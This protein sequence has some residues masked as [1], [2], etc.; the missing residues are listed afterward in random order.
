MSN[1]PQ[2]SSIT[3]HYD[4]EYFKYQFEIGRFGG[5]ANTSKFSAYIRPDMNVLDFGC[6]CG[7]L[8]ANL[9]GKQK[10]GI[11]VNPVARAE[12]A[13]SG[14]PTVESA[15]QVPDSWADIVVSNHALEH[16]QRPLD[17]LKALVPKVALGGLVVFVV[18]CELIKNRYSNTDPNH[19]LYS[20]S[21]MSLGNLF[22]EASL[23]VIESKAYV[24]CWPPRFMSRTLRAI[25]GRLLFE[26]GCRAYGALTYLNLTPALCQA[27]VVAR[28]N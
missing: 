26:A 14:I 5:W 20:W 27:R 12:A 25:G 11:E 10:L 17:E 22:A 15:A 1:S 6:G 24:H 19:H 2:V 16:C 3:S 8:L 23:T 7:H 21:P 9:A 13:R 28:R 18:P 4:A